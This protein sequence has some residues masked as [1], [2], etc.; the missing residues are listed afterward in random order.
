MLP[1]SGPHSFTK[2][3]VDETTEQVGRM[4]TRSDFSPMVKYLPVNW[5]RPMS[6]QKKQRVA[7][8]L[9]SERHPT[10]PEL[11]TEAKRL[12]K[13]PLICRDDGNH[14]PVDRQSDLS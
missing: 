7:Y 13:S 6:N 5:T 11:K 3:I 10:S 1:S 2:F 4:A 8:R 14:V 12:W 9:Y